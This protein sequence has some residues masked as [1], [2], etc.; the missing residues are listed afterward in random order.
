MSPEARYDQADAGSLLQLGE[1]IALASP[2]DRQQECQRLLKLEQ[3]KPTIEV[4]LHLL[5]AQ[6]LLE[7]CGEISKNL[8]VLKARRADIKDESARRLLTVTEQL[9]GRLN[10]DA[11]QRKSLERQLKA[12]N[13]RLQS[14]NRQTKTRESEIKTLQDKLDA[15]QS[16][17]QDLG[18]SQDGR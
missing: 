1:S 6:I 10:S 5:M 3:V 17:E 13:Q 14:A 15:L 11:E 12:A 18:G 4:R 2:Q 16:I 7:N 9:L 8:E